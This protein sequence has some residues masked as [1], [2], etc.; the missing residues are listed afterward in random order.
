[1]HPT[2]PTVANATQEEK[3]TMKNN[4][5][6][7]EN[8]VRKPVT[9]KAPAAKVAKAPAAKVAKAPAAKVAKAPAAKAAKA[10]GEPT[11]KRLRNQ[12][13]TDAIVAGKSNDDV[14][15]LLQ[16]QVPGV[17]DMPKGA[18]GYVLWLRRDLRNREVI[19]RDFAETHA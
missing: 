2:D 10:D 11:P 3:K 7:T 13:A 5:F 9:A 14:T 1:M 18:R 17:D 19:T 15:A 8:L 6:A 12:V 16:E 4:A